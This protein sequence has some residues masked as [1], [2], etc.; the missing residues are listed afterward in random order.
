[1]NDLLIDSMQ[2]RLIQISENSCKLTE[3][4]QEKHQT[5]D[6]FAIKGLRNRL[7]HDYGSVD[8]QIIYDTLT[9]DI[10]ILK[11]ELIK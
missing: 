7:V 4:F 5:I 8:Y 3:S 10:S 6:F 1:M 11:E 9:K 2:F